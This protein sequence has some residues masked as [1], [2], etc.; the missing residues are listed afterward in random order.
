MLAQELSDA[1]EK[2][3]GLEERLAEVEIVNARLEAAA[4]TTAQ[5]LTEVSR[6]W[7]SVYEAMRR[8]ETIDQ[9]TSSERDNG[10]SRA[11]RDG[12][13]VPQRPDY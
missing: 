4:L 6:H 12:V 10:A 9:E 13:A 5:G 7:D 11:R 8:P 1:G 2:L 3:R